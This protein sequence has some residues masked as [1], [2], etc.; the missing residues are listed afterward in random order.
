MRRK[1]KGRMLAVQ[2]LYQLD[3]RGDIFLDGMDEFIES[4]AR[5]EEVRAFATELAH[6]CAEHRDELDAQI[7]AAAEHWDIARMAAVDR[8][9]LR[10][11]AYELLHQPDVPPKVAIDEAIRLAKKMGSAESG[12]FVNGIL[13]RIMSSRPARDLAGTHEET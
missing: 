9:I 5:N 10:L 1:S 4:S 12:A 3:L 11:G 6:G 2:T 13:D 8:A 7:A